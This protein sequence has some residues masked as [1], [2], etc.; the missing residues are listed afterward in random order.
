M[1]KSKRQHFFEWDALMLECIKCKQVLPTDAFQKSKRWLFGFKET[2]KEC[3]KKDYVLNKDSIL[4]KR[5][6]YYN[7][8]SEAKKEYQRW[9]Y[10]THD[11]QIREQ[12]KIYRANNPEKIKSGRQ[13]YYSRNKETIR[14]K[15]I[16]Y[17]TN[18]NIELWF[19]WVKFHG[20]AHYYVGKNRLKPQECSICWKKWK[21]VCHH[22]S[23]E[24]FDK[25]KDVVFVCDSCH[26][27]IHHWLVECPEPVDLI[28]LNAHM[29]TIL[30][31]KDLECL[32]KNKIS[33]DGNEIV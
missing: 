21:V 13:S 3:R 19:D 26:Q 4:L 17:R 29:P 1:T 22:P 30:T 24:T 32:N 5:K 6:E 12:H 27:N 18:K 25:W 2:C 31:D 20:K 16:N 7:R 15:D 11:E 23:Y 10:Y 8:V 9:Y 33:N 14:S 28:Q